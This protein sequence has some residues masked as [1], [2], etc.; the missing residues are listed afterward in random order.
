MLQGNL[1]HLPP[2]FDMPNFNAQ[3]AGEGTSRV[4]EMSGTLLVEALSSAL[5]N[6]SQTDRQQVRVHILIKEKLLKLRNFIF[7]K[8]HKHSDDFFN[9]IFRKCCINLV[10]N[11]F[12]YDKSRFRV[13]HEQCTFTSFQTNLCYTEVFPNSKLF[14]NLLHRC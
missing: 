11:R 4:Q 8:L 2:G 10:R 13:M 5:V 14:S 7:S 3:S 12:N 9:A 1:L 6:A